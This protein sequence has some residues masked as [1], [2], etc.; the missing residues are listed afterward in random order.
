M[1]DEKRCETCIHYQKEEYKNGEQDTKCLRTFLVWQVILI[2]VGGEEIRRIFEPTICG[3]Q[4]MLISWK[5]RGQG[6]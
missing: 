4:I 3:S 2:S 1:A 5:A 6:S